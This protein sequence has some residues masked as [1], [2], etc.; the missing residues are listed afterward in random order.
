MEWLL[1]GAADT[2]GAYVAGGSALSLLHRHD[3]RVAIA[4]GMVLKTF[5]PDR[6][7]RIELLAMVYPAYWRWSTRGLITA[8]QEHRHK[9]TASGAHVGATGACAASA[10]ADVY[11]AAWQEVEAAMRD[12]QVVAYRDEQRVALL[13]RSEAERTTSGGKGRFGYHPFS[14]PASRRNGAFEAHRLLQDVRSGQFESACKALDQEWAASGASYRRSQK[15]LLDHNIDLWKDATYNRIRFLRWLFKAEGMFV[16]IGPDE[17]DL[18]TGMGSGAQKGCQVSGIESFKDAQAAVAEL[19]KLPAASGAPYNLDDLICWLCLSQHKEAQA[20]TKLPAPAAPVSVEADLGVALTSQERGRRLTRKVL[21]LR[22]GDPGASQK[23]VARAKRW[24]RWVWRRPSV[25]TGTC[26]L[27]A[28]LPVLVQWLPV[29]DASSLCQ[30]C[31]RLHADGLFGPQPMDATRARVADAVAK[32]LSLQGPLASALLQAGL[33]SA[34]VLALRAQAWRWLSECKHLGQDADLIGLAL[35]RLSAKVALTPEHAS[36]CLRCLGSEQQEPR[37]HSMECLLVN[38]LWS[39]R[40]C[41]LEVA[42]PPAAQPLAPTAAVQRPLARTAPA[43]R[44]LARP[45]AARQLLPPATPQPLPQHG[46]WHS[47]LRKRDR[48]V[49]S[50]VCP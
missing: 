6:S 8:M 32:T 19:R 9:L 49:I 37:Q 45:A 50:R 23:Q 36:I 38:T 35:L 13:P 10:R 44:A 11:A 1:G 43:Q 41:R 39:D 14:N 48:A 7:R 27:A 24:A 34:A 25:A 47:P 2:V 28:A 17:W 16:V 29:A 15:I 42:Q 20:G 46:G 22:T 26:P 31:Q 30:T 12:R 3:I 33:S 5:V 21:L 18:L 4:C 40:S